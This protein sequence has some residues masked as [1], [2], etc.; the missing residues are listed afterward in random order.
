MYK[1]LIFREEVVTIIRTYSF[2]L[3]NYSIHH[4]KYNEVTGEKGKDAMSLCF[5][6]L[7][8][9]LFGYALVK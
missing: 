6:L 4:C 9:V 2:Q 5:L 7:L 3:C 1:A 8:F